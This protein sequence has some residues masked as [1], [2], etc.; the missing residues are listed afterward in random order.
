MVKKLYTKLFYHSLYHFSGIA[1][2]YISAVF[3]C[4][5]AGDDKDEH[6]DTYFSV[7]E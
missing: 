3:F 5:R 6:N 2:G 4:G 1:F 7:V